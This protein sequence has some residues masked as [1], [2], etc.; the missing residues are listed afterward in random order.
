[1]SLL[2]ADSPCLGFQQLP[3]AIG[4]MARLVD[5]RRGSAAADTCRVIAAIS[6]ED[7]NQP[8]QPAHFGDEP[9]LYPFYFSQLGLADSL[10]HAPPPLLHAKATRAAAAFCRVSGSPTIP[11]MRTR[12]RR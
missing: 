9:T 10:A 2:L 4:I 12:P 7:H 8:L 5:S 11:P 1:M 3:R 6:C